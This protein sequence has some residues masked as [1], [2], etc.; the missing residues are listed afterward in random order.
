MAHGVT[1]ELLACLYCQVRLPTSIT[2]EQYIKHIQVKHS[3]LASSEV[4][5]A[6]VHLKQ[7][8]EKNP[9]L[10][11]SAATFLPPRPPPCPKKNIHLQTV[12]DG[13]C[14][15]TGAVRPR[16]LEVE[17]E[18]WAEN[19]GDSETVLNNGQVLGSKEELI[20]DQASQS[21]VIHNQVKEVSA[22]SGG[23]PEAK[24]DVE[25]MGYADQVKSAQG[26]SKSCKVTTDARVPN[27]VSCAEKV[28]YSVALIQDHP[29]EK[30]HAKDREEE[31]EAMEV[32]VAGVAV[33]ENK[34]SKGT[35][36]VI[37]DVERKDSTDM[38]D[39]EELGTA[40]E[41]KNKE[42]VES[43]MNV[44]MAVEA[45]HAVG[46]ALEDVKC[47][48]GK[49]KK[50]G[51][52]VAGCGKMFYSRRC[53]EDHM[54]KTHGAEKLSCP[55]L[56]CAAEFG[57]SRGLERHLKNG[58]HFKNKRGT[59]KLID[60]KED[61][62]TQESI[63]NQ[64]VQQ[65]KKRAD[66]ECDVEGCLARFSPKKKCKEDHMRMEH[67]QSKLV[68]QMC[69]ASYFSQDGLS[70]HVKKKHKRE[71]AASK[72]E[73]EYQRDKDNATSTVGNVED[74]SPIAV[75]VQEPEVEV[76]DMEIF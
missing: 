2:Q 73:V 38:S 7:N 4:K 74:K 21:V 58:Q 20:K 1:R 11:K 53:M 68:C 52:A 19:V 66:I 71:I 24:A 18:M 45:E 6:L 15:S 5:R 54:R 32:E 44:G 51:C 9:R 23:G 29:K 46:V 33:G 34:L 69:E 37:G 35:S 64:L 36:E 10:T 27:H 42:K 56:C 25:D 65:V 40:M 26:R 17:D 49:V 43:N 63:V 48:K 13:G 47:S 39:I 3:V 16:L 12:V 22:A 41:V 14:S 62:K 76:L 28:L 70:Q 72:H 75:K 30:Y 61:L 55:K 59:S 57:S 8:K 31:F 50:V 67:G 60:K